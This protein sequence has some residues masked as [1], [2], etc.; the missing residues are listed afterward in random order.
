MKG[1]PIGRQRVT[2]VSWAI[3]I[4]CAF[5]AL[6]VA[7]PQQG[8][9][10]LPGRPGPIVYSS[11]IA[12]AGD[13]NGSKYWSGI[14]ELSL[15]GKTKLTSPSMSVYAEPS[16][17]PNGRLI[18]FRK[19]PG[20]QL[21][22][23]PRYRP[24]QAK[25]ITF[26]SADNQGTAEPIFS[27]DGRSIYFGSFQGLLTPTEGVWRLARYNVGSGEV[28]HLTGDFVSDGSLVPA[29]S[30]DGRLIAFNSGNR[31]ASSIKILSV[32][33]RQIRTIPSSVAA[34]SASFSP[35]GEFLA[36]TGMVGGTQQ[37]FS[38]R[39]D[40]S[41]R[42]QLTRS[43]LTKYGPQFS[44]DGRKIAYAES[45]TATESRIAILNLRTGKARRID[46][47]RGQVIPRQWT[48]KGLFRIVGY[49]SNN[50][51]LNIRVFNGGRAFLTG[52]RVKP[53]SRA[54]N[55]RRILKIPVRWRG[56]YQ[57]AVVTVEFRPQGGLPGRK[58]IRIHL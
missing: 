50:G 58:E 39:L 3:G 38:S 24:D 19:N 57:S 30:P 56:P 6:V 15:A 49:D 37:I 14:F 21:W 16:V 27:P 35:N 47:P 42:K 1:D 28:E 36:Y 34:F 51:T 32:A 43:D 48:R 13:T 12:S 8:K 44:P 11:L 23:G 5:I 25:Q 7:V 4:L 20:D 53:S 31:A 41:K 52:S 2:S 45:E 26:F 40:G 10:A 18:A 55:T 29:V 33:S 22:V 9:A 54:S 46:S 17:S